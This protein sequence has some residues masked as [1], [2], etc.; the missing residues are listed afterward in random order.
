[1]N[2]S[3]ILS[4]APMRGNLI[5]A[6]IVLLIGMLFVALMVRIRTS[7]ARSLRWMP[8]ATLIIG[9]VLS[10]L[11]VA[12][13]ALVVSR[14]G[15]QLQVEDVWAALPPVLIIGA[16][17]GVVASVA[18]SAALRIAE[19]QTIDDNPNDQSPTTTVP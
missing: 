11:F 10:F 5:A 15:N 7:G 8:I 16:F 18:F 3:L 9:P 2:P 4:A 12:I 13:T 17:A 14:R 1:V 6:A 19:R